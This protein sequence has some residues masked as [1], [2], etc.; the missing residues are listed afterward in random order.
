MN[1][2]HMQYG[3]SRR[4]PNQMWR[5]HKYATDASLLMCK[6]IVASF[7]VFCFHHF[8]GEKCVL[9]QYIERPGADNLFATGIMRPAHHNSHA[10]NSNAPQALGFRCVNCKAE[11]GSRVAMA[12]H[13]RHPTSIGTPCEDPKNAKSISY[14]GRASVLSSIVR[15]HDTLGTPNIFKCVDLCIVCIF[16]AWNNVYNYHN[17]YNCNIMWHN[18]D[19]TW[20]KV[21]LLQGENPDYCNYVLRLLE[22]FQIIPATNN[23]KQS[24]QAHTVE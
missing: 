22:L 21:S 11:F 18:C 23:V 19:I 14:T 3:F 7:V 2:W 10:V 20:N 1:F 9:P 24:V 13:R 15:E 5:T 6:T 8:A 12:C 16:F 17:I 4:I